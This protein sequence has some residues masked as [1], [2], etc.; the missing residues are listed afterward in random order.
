MVLYFTPQKKPKN[1]LFLNERLFQN[2]FNFIRFLKIILRLTKTL[3]NQAPTQKAAKKP[4][5][6]ILNKDVSNQAPTQK[7]AKKPPKNILNKDALIKPRI[8]AIRV[9]Q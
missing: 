4:P 1:P 3:L 9:F 7:A 6:N 5:K 8:I 2:Y